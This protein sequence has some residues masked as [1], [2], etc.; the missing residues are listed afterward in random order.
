MPTGTATSSITST[1]QQL[2]ASYGPAA[3][4]AGHNAAA[5]YFGALTTFEV[6][7]VLVTT[8]FIVGIVVIIRKTG[9]LRVRLERIDDVILR[10]DRAKKAAEKSWGEVERHFFSGSASDLKIAVIKADTL[11]GEALREGGIHGTDLGERLKSLT[12]ADL[13]NL[14]HVWEAHRLRN[15]IAHEAD[16][17]LKRDLAER[18]LT[19][20]DDAL[21]HLGFLKESPVT[22]TGSGSNSGSPP[23]NRPPQ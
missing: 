12:A 19:V 9:W 15:R 4:A 7:S 18:A 3:Q 10:S 20:Y 17:V 2:E 13:P 22:G 1:I 21:V 16:F 11:L 8:A 5:A 14:D 6:I 23:A